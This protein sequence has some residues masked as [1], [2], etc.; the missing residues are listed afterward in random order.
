MN[1]E[2][3][4][5]G[6]HA[7]LPQTTTE[8]E[9][10]DI[11]EVRRDIINPHSLIPKCIAHKEALCLVEKARFSGAFC[12]S[13]AKIAQD[14]VL[15]TNLCSYLVSDDLSEILMSVYEVKSP[16]FRQVGFQSLHWRNRRNE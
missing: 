9:T 15:F 16:A 3:D 4:S 5:S 12:A 7:S 11:L 13:K 8:C 1:K 6:S 10:R 2:S 14:R